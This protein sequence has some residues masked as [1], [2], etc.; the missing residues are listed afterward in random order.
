M[1]LTRLN[2]T[3][4]RDLV[5]NRVRL[6]SARLAFTIG[7]FA[8][9]ISGLFPTH[10]AGALG[11]ASPQRVLV[12]PDVGRLILGHAEVVAKR[13]SPVE[14]RLRADHH[15]G[16]PSATPCGG[17]RA[18]RVG[19]P[20]FPGVSA[21]YG[22]IHLIAFARAVA[23]STARG[24]HRARRGIAKAM[25][26]FARLRTERL[27]LLAAASVLRVKFPAAFAAIKNHVLVDHSA[28]YT[29]GGRDCRTI[30]REEVF[31]L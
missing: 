7:F 30:L 10:A 18:I 21:F 25:R 22:A 24:A 31:N 23:G 9:R 3:A 13:L 1:S 6:S 11:A 28:H 4:H 15:L 8:R 14:V 12:A 27:R 2:E 20:R 19:L 17:S 26:F 5:V 29:T 16:T